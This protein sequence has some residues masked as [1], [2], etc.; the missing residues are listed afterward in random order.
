MLASLKLQ[1]S[2]FSLYTYVLSN[3]ILKLF[4]TYVNKECEEAFLVSV[5]C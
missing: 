1:T 5:D 4:V 2:M 3:I